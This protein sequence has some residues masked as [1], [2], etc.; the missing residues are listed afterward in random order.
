MRIHERILKSVVF[1]GNAPHETFV[2]HGTGFLTFVGEREKAFQQIVTAKHV[3]EDIPGPEVHIRLNRLDGYAEVIATELSEWTAHP[4]SGVDLAV[5]PVAIP[6][7]QFQQVNVDLSSDMIVQDFSAD[8]DL[9]G[10]GDEVY[11]VGMFVQRMGEAR[12]HPIIRVGTVAAMP[13]E[14]IET[15][16]G[17]H[18]AILIE[19]RSI[20]GLSGSPVFVASS[21]LE[22]SGDNKVQPRP[23]LYFRFAGVLLGHDEVINPKDKVPIRRPGAKRTDE[24]IEISVMLNT[25]I[26][27]VAPATDVIAAVEQPKLAQLRQEVMEKER[28]SG[29]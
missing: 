6:L 8:S 5:C 29:H 23:K 10:L 25:G 19:I 26:G 13:M 9:I 22:I 27:I 21:M 1:V 4:D 28:R 3:L 2:P 20:D 17:H 16:Y 24:P 14:K 15:R 18:D 11:V 7:D 12:N